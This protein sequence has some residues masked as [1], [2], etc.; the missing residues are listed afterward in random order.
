M[1]IRYDDTIAADA[2]PWWKKVAAV[3]GY[4]V[5]AGVAYLVLAPVFSMVCHV[6]GVVL[7]FIFD[8]RAPS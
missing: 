5:A 3:L 1:T 8:G 4:G 6:L 2:W 7:R